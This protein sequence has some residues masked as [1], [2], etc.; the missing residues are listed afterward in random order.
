MVSVPRNKLAFAQSART[1][2]R[3]TESVTFSLPGTGVNDNLSFKAN[4]LYLSAPAGRQPRGFDEYMAI[5][6]TFTVLGAK[7]SANFSFQGYAAPA[8]EGPTGFE[9]NMM[10]TAVPG[11]TSKAAVPSAFCAI[12]KSAQALDATYPKDAIEQGKCVWKI[13]SPTGGHPIVRSSLKINE[14]FGD[15]NL[16]GSSGYTGSAASNPTEL[17]YFHIIVA[18]MSPQQTELPHAQCRITALVSIDFDVVFTEPKKLA[19]S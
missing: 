16:V 2:L 15:G 7:C 9:T 10:Q 3:L 8:T 12:Q 5:Y 13:M 19:A 11:A 18:R 4:G 6:E 1:T 17:L 14:F